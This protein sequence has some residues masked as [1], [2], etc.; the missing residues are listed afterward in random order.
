MKSFESKLA[1]PRRV[2]LLSPAKQKTRLL[3]VTQPHQR[4]NNIL[5]GPL[6]RPA[7]LWLAAHMPAW[8]TPDGLTGVGFVASITIFFGYYLTNIDKNFLWLASFGFI[9]NWFGDS[10]DGTLARLRKIERPRYGFFV[11]HTIDA[12]SEVLIFLGIGLSPYVDFKIAC[13]ALIAYMLL[14]ILVFISTYV[15]GV[16]RIS[17][18]NLGPT[19]MRLIAV[20]ANTVVFFIGN[21]IM[22]LPIFGVVTF[23]NF[24]AL[25]LSALFFGAFVV[26]AYLQATELAKVEKIGK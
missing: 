4:V 23:Y 11:D 24:V 14:S 15:N 26:M 2:K 16:F 10:L 8:V 9:L 3:D 5:L 20:I 12:F 13:V 25:A 18:L 1:R 6:E 17:Y 22:Q 7:L 19:E 21:P